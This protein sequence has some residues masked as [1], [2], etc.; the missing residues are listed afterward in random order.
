[1]N[2][3]IR[4]YLIAHQALG[5]DLQNTCDT[6][7]VS[8]DELDR[9]CAINELVWAAQKS[10]RETTAFVMAADAINTVEDMLHTEVIQHGLHFH[11]L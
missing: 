10:L 9:L 2:K 4:N 11:G 7:G 3:I 5:L 6:K 1:M 8:N